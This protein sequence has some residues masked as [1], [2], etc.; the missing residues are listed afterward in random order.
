[1]E[2]DSL[3]KDSRVTQSQRSWTCPET[4]LK[5]HQFGSAPLDLTPPG[6]SQSDQKYSAVI[7]NSPPL[8]LPSTIAH[9][10]PTS[11]KPKKEGSWTAF[12][13]DEFKATNIGVRKVKSGDIWWLR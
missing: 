4:A 3:S 13:L 2:V 12:A 5:K 1:M 8:Y 10:R 9:A 11:Q 7:T 6:L